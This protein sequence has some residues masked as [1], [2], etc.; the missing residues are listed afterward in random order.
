M[1]NFILIATLS[2]FLTNCKGD[3]NVIAAENEIFEILAAGAFAGD[4]I[5][6]TSQNSVITAQSDWNSLVSLLATEHHDLSGTT[7][8]FN[9]ENIVFVRDEPRPDG[10]YAIVVDKV[11]YT[12][13]EVQFYINKIVNNAGHHMPIQPFCIA[14][15]SKTN[16]PVNFY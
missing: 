4:N 9:Q 13:T 15:I 16:L 3:D 11:L 7:I 6:T 14:K 1:K 5:T 12:S 10:K 2:I 8:N